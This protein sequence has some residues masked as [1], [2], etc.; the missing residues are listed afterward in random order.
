MLDLT[1]RAVRRY[2]QSMTIWPFRQRRP[3]G[4]GEYVLPPELRRIETS[5][6]RRFRLRLADSRQAG[7]AV[8]LL[9]AR[10]GTELTVASA[11]ESVLEV[12]STFAPES[13]A[14]LRPLNALHDHGVR[15][16][17]LEFSDLVT[18][19]DDAALRQVVEAWDQF[20]NQGPHRRR[21]ERLA[22]MDLLERCLVQFGRAGDSGPG[23]RAAWS[24]GVKCITFNTSRA[25]GRVIEEAARLRDAFHAQSF[26]SAAV[27][28]IQLATLAGL[29]V[30]VAPEAVARLI[31]RRGY[32]SQSACHLAAALRYPLPGAVTEAL[33]TVAGEKGERACAALAALGKAKPTPEVRAT[34]D[35]AI[36]ADDANV[37]AAALD[38]LAH[39]WGVEARPAWKEFLTSKMAPMR[40]SAEIVIGIHGTEEDLADAAAHL[41]KLA[42][43]K[44]AMSI[45]SPRGNEIVGL[46]VRHR[47]HPTARAG[48]DDLSA[49]WDRLPA[50]LRGWLTEHHPWLD[51]AN[52]AD[53]PSE[54][55]AVPEEE[56]SWPPP[57]IERSGDV[58]TLEFDDAAAHHP[59]RERFEE[60]VTAHPSIELL[61]GDREWLS[62]RV[63]GPDPEAL[64]HQ[65][66]VAAGSMG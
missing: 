23:R 20:G 15:V 57:A 22:G 66:W 62:I 46:L 34:I 47:D 11:E 48:L 53:Q 9:Q 27:E 61:E 13:A 65:L 52:R 42:R 35:G 64:I 6:P 50:D 21:V 2:D 59:V 26:V 37:R 36:V 58:V 63:S 24:F 43:S 16:S 41:A 38:T 32:L 39:L 3:G 18:E 7:V 14:V 25:E 8:D 44:A 49:R 29:E 56:L 12:A 19:L 10:L 17:R 55:A 60:L 5:T 40:W 33:R 28:R 45:S 4:E 30:E 54:S 31:G 1:M 51:P